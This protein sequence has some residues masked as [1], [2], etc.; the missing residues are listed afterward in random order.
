MNKTIRKLNSL[1][2]SFPKED[3]P[4]I[5]KHINKRSFKDLWDIVQSSIYKVKK[6]RE[7]YMQTNLDDM[8]TFQSELNCY[9]ES[10]GLDDDIDV[11]VPD[12]FLEV[13]EDDEYY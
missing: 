9:L 10:S 13:Y 3:I 1:V 11:I 8:Y 12:E 2:K 6:N 7:K 4:H 5:E